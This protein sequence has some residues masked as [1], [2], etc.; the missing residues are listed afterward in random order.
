MRPMILVRIVRLLSADGM[1]Q[2]FPYW[3]GC[4]P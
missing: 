1:A 4:G 3:N 2:T